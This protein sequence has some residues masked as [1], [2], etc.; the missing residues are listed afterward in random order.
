MQ[1]KKASMV[2]LCAVAL[3]AVVIA[4]E[5]PLQRTSRP[6]ASSAK[7]APS[8]SSNF[9]AIV[10]S[11]QESSEIITT[12]RANDSD[13]GVVY[14]VKEYQGHI[15]V[16]R[17][18]EASPFEEIKIDVAIFPKADQELLKEGIKAYGTQDLNRIIED[19]KG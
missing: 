1:L 3:L 8:V 11:S 15:G 16:F 2:F 18:E 14:T 5:Y 12:A 13:A 6:P 4:V 9:T 19:Y 10:P 17:G 7:K